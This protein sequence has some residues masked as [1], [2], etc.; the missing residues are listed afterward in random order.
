MLGQH[1]LLLGLKQWT[2]SLST[3]MWLLPAL[4]TPPSTLNLSFPGCWASN[5]RTHKS[6]SYITQL[7]CLRC[8]LS[9]L[10]WSSL[11][12]QTWSAWTPPSTCFFFPCTYNKTLLYTLGVAMSFSLFLFFFFISLHI[13]NL[14]LMPTDKCSYHPWLKK[15]LFTANGDYHSNPQLDTMQK[16]TVPSKSRPQW[17]HLYHSSSIYDLETMA[18]EGAERC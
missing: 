6:G 18:E 15:P 2:N 7:F 16:S 13:L 3:C 8:F 14:I 5:P 4:F 12:C 10:S 9:L 17:I 1:F 11:V